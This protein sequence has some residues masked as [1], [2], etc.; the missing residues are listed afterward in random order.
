VEEEKLKKE[1]DAEREKEREKEEEKKKSEDADGAGTKRCVVLS[2]Y[3]TR[4]LNSYVSSYYYVS[5]CAS[6]SAVVASV[7]VAVCV[8]GVC[9]EAARRAHRFCDVYIWMH[10]HKKK[11]GNFKKKTEAQRPAKTRRQRRLRPRC[12]E[13]KNTSAYIHI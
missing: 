7:F 2:S 9:M 13:K 12:R 6:P 4:V 8:C 5:F 11:N 3:C 1:R 10:T